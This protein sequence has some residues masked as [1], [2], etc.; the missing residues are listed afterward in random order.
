M[1]HN[2][3]MGSDGILRVAFIGD[4]S[5]ADFEAYHRDITPFIEASTPENPL[6]IILDTHQTGKLS[7]TVRQGF[8]QLNRDLR[9]GHTGIIGASRP[10]HVFINFLLKATQRNNVEFFDSDENVVEWLNK[11]KQEHEL[12]SQEN[13]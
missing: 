12:I 6:Y 10:I 9:L 13:A 8:T 5:R 11:T 4:V 1:T 2:I 7:S 3:K